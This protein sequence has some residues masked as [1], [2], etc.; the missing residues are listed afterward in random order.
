VSTSTGR[1]SPKR[2]VRVLV[3]IAAELHLE[4]KKAA[5]ER[6]DLPQTEVFLDAFAHHHVRVREKYGDSAL[7]TRDGLPSRPRARPRRRHVGGVSACTLFVTEEE[8]EV[9]DALAEEL[10]MNRSELVSHLL[11]AELAGPGS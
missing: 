4:L 11:E 8:R 6:G 5:Q 2:K 3:S 1:P 9:V 7:T 10:A